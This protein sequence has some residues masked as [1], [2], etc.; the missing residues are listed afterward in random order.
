MLKSVVQDLVEFHR[1][2][3]LR[4]QNKSSLDNF[5]DFVSTGVSH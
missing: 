3:F 5:K 2:T 1:H 4:K